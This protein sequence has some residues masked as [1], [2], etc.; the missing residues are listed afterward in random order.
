MPRETCSPTRL[1]T[2]LFTGFLSTA[3]AAPKDV[4]KDAEEDDYIRFNEDDAK[5]QLQTAS[6]SYSHE[7]G[8]KVELIGVVHIG[9]KAY[10]KGLNEDFE[11][12]D[13]LL[14]EMVGGDPDKPLTKE[15]LQKNK[16]NPLR[17]FQLLI[18]GMM[19]LEF[20]LDHIDY[21]ATNFV[22]ADMDL[23][24]FQRRQKE[25]GENILS[26][27]EKSVQAQQKAAAEGKENFDFAAM[28]KILNEEGGPN[29]TK[30]VMG[31]QFHKIE[32]MVSGM[33]GSDGS[34]LVSERNLAAL[35]IL[36][37]ER[38]AGKKSLGIFYGAAHLPDFDKRLRKD[39][40]FKRGAVTWHTAWDIEKAKAKAEKP[41]PAP[42]KE[43][44]A[45]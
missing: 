31:R 29:G 16:K 38:G 23:E 34:V 19:E 12:Y 33:E 10:Y 27:L 41:D 3:M 37:R 43:K 26:L 14:Y 6:I 32:S 35:E 11:K 18:A 42:A 2:L 1:L 17:F 44:K 39:L 5:A 25:K 20:Q 28:F 45:A 36:K 15:D 9:D 22:H 40:G 7:D 4:A 24:T 30:L 13:A 8:T 21:T